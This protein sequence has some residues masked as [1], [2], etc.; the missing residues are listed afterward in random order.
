MEY[1][2]DVRR[3]WVPALQQGLLA[4][5]RP[6]PSCRPRLHGGPLPDGL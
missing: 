6:V 2:E 3:I 5:A 1:Q 4:A